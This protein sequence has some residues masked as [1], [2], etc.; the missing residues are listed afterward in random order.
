MATTPQRPAAR[1]AAPQRPAQT[2][3]RPAARPAAARPPTPAPAQVPALLQSGA[4]ALPEDLAAELALEAK[5]AAAKERPSVGRF[6]LKSG[7]MSYGGNPIPGNNLDVIIVGG[8]YRNVFYSGRYDP[9]NIV[10]PDCFALADEDDGM[11]PHENVSSPQ[12]ENCAEC[13][14]GQWGSDPNGGRGKACKQTRR[15]IVMPADVLE[16][17]DPAAAILASELAIVDVPVTSVKNYANLVNSLAATINLPVWAVVTNLL[18]VPDA[19]TQFKLNFTAMRPAGDA[20]VLRS[21]KKR[22][23]EALRIALTP[24]QGT[25]GEADPEADKQPP[26][27]AAPVNK[28]TAKAPAAKTAPAR[29]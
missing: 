1:T 13:E 16:S 24:Y 3:A 18:V 14:K 28:F 26:A 19:R 22:R 29:R 21:L 6:S 4:I 2:A 9:D 12:H 5:D 27:K 7:V 25:G 11:E 10:N 15:L 8:A 23:D 20:D 17:E